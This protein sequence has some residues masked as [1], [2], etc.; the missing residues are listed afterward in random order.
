MIIIEI[1]I[2]DKSEMPEPNLPSSY[3]LFL[4]EGKFPIFIL[5]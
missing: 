3:K 5:K 2:T 4:N 1:L